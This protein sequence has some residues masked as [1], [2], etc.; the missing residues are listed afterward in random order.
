MV[1]IS[2]ELRNFFSHKKTTVDFTQFD[3]A[4]LIG[5][6]EGDYDLSNGSGKSAIFES[7][8]WCLFNKARVA[9]MDDIILWGEESCSVSMTFKQGDVLYRVVR[10]RS[11]VTGRA[12]VTFAYLSEDNDWID[13]S[14]ST[15]RLT[16]SKIV[17]IVK[18]DYK[19]FINS[20]YFR[21]ND[22]SEFAESDPGRK[23][24]ILK[25]II[26]LSKW[27][28]YEKESKARLKTIRSESEILQAK[29][30]ELDVD[31]IA[32]A[33]AVSQANSLKEELKFMTQKK[34]QNSD[35]LEKMINRYQ[36]LK[37]S[38]DTDQW[39]KTVAENKEIKIKIERLEV[40]RSQLESA[41]E[42]TQQK[43]GPLISQIDELESKLDSIV[44]DKE[45]DEKIKKVRDSLIVY[46]SKSST[47]KNMLA[48]LDEKNIDEEVCNVCGQDI[49]ED[50]HS[51]LVHTHNEEREKYN[52]EFIFSNNKIE[53]SNA[54]LKKYE[55][56]QK[57]NKRANTFRGKL[58]TL[59]AQKEIGEE[60]LKNKVE[61]LKNVKSDIATLSEKVKS[62]IL[63]LD[64][65]KNDDFQKLHSEIEEKRR[66][67][68]SLEDKIAN[69]NQEIGILSQKIKTLT[70]RTEKM[71]EDKKE[72]LAINKKRAAYEKL[73]KLLGK[74]G[75]QTILLNAVIE[76][77]EKTA[78]QI[79][80]SICNE[81]LGVFLE[82]QRV[83]S[84]GVSLVDTLD[85]RVKKDGMTQ[86]FKSL[87]G[88]E[89]FRI[90]LSLRIALS[91]ISSRHGGSSLEFLLLDEI[92]SP[93]DRHGTENLF[94]NVI[95]SLE[96]K[97][98]ILVITHND[99]LKE[100]FNNVIDV[101]KVNGESTAQFTQK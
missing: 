63:V 79:L 31:E 41:I 11:R 90:S 73:S 14:G 64:S 78:N 51:E 17:G 84:D 1:P 98:K 58:R 33:K 30:E 65:L 61:E 3:S 21:Q 15:A 28:D 44:V 87:S 4:L 6:T 66:L 20:A 74:N 53:E 57:D 101:T 13:I 56:V 76:D 97:Y 89:Q 55:A 95:R 29:V 25:S 23:K 37:R 19:T 88:G 62:N 9:A 48:M 86:N 71:R 46:R 75:I 27:D 82:T 67:K 49:S 2:L 5:N 18:F 45:I 93:L 8:L 77:L 83:G 99:S 96:K 52:K 60:S 42:Q 69:Q 80:V 54:L 38:L 68:K 10:S 91:E 7:I 92:N 100:R 24:E 36:E 72:L 47:A 70:E 26:D 32:L 35:S 59:R 39:D 43:L 16:N 40:K 22:I 81:P 85:L 50:L 94:V 34:N 12:E